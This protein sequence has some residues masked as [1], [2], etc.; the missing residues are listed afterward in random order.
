MKPFQIP[1]QLEGISLLKDGCL[2]L[3]FHTQEIPSDQ[4]VNLMNY[5]QQFGYLLFKPDAFSETEIPEKNTDIEGRKIK[6]PSQRLRAVI[7]VYG[8][9]KNIPKEEQD[10]FYERQMEAIIDKYKEKLDE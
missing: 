5:Y 10:L 1:S 9:Q 7:Y 2:S 4:K 3:R 6:T 8:K